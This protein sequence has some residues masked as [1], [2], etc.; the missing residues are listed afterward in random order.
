MAHSLG[1]A[2]FQTQETKRGGWAGEE[3]KVNTNQHLDIGVRCA[4]PNNTQPQ[5]NPN[6][7]YKWL[8]SFLSCYLVA[9][10]WL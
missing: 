4:R 1:R 10:V 6:L 8:A 2:Q 3:E 7:Y 5:Y 9:G